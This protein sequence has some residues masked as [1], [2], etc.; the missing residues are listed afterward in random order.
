M[1][2]RLEKGMKNIY[3]I[4]WTENC[5]RNTGRPGQ[6]RENYTVI[7]LTPTV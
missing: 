7:H 1:D 6:R 3:E 2:M 4:L 5:K